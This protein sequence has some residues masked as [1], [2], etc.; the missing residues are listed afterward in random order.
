MMKTSTDKLTEKEE[1]VMFLIWEHGPCSIKDLIEY[2]PDPKPHVNTVSTFVRTLETKGFV[3]HKQGRY[4]SFNYFAVKSKSE[5]KKNTFRKII[6]RYFGNSFSMVSNLVE[7]EE[8]DAEQLRR[9]LE[10]VEKK[11]I[12]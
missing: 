2:Y 7:N 6:D 12:K 4:G 8:L 11:N 1:E 3:D 10:M 5:Y 9:L